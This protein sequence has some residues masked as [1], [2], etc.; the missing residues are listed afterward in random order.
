MRAHLS[1]SL[2]PYLLRWTHYQGQVMRYF[3]RQPCHRL[4][5]LRQWNGSSQREFF[6][7]RRSRWP[8]VLQR[9]LYA[10]VLVNG[11]RGVLVMYEHILFPLIFF[12]FLCEM[13][14]LYHS[15]TTLYRATGAHHRPQYT[16]VNTFYAK[17]DTPSTQA[18]DKG[19]LAPTCVT[20]YLIL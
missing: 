5:S 13:Y 20:A 4:M 16:Y 15:G 3:E 7:T 19:G 9:R 6:V 17:K 10:L 8:H 12:F 11:F 14:I 1:S 2:A 18:P